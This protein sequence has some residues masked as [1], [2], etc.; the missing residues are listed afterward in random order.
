MPH[1]TIWIQEFSFPVDFPPTDPNFRARDE[2]KM[3]KTR[4]D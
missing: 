4:G 2:A 1:E 3:D